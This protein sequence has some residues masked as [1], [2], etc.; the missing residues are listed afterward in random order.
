MNCIT[1]RQGRLLLDMKRLRERFVGGKSS[2]LAR[3]WGK[4][5]KYIFSGVNIG[6][7]ISIK[8][9]VKQTRG[10]GRTV[11]P[12]E[13]QSR[14]LPERALESNSRSLYPISFGVCY[15]LG[16]MK[17]RHKDNTRRKDIRKR[18]TRRSSPHRIEVNI[19]KSRQTPKRQWASLGLATTIVA[20]IPDLTIAL[21]H[22]T[23]PKPG[24]RPRDISSIITIVL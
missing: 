2:V 6:I 18:Q 21:V 16:I 19:A 10:R 20:T 8:T 3:P 24:A 23:R 9:K 17:R 5:K 1:I 22:A 12:L 14:L 7:Y 13:R 4:K 11:Q 15:I